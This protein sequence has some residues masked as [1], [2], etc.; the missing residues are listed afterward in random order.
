MECAFVFR[1]DADERLGIGHAMRMLA[2]AE[3]ARA[4]GAKSALVAR[5]LP[6]PIAAQFEALGVEVDILGDRAAPDF[7][8]AA[9]EKHIRRKGWAVIDAPGATETQLRALCARGCRLAV[10]DDGDRDGFGGADLIVNPNIEAEDAHYAARVSAGVALALGLPFLP[11]R[12]AYAEARPDT[13]RGERPRVLVTMGGADPGGLTG[14]IAAALAPLAP[15]LDI[16]VAIGPAFPDRARCANAIAAI[17][18][19]IESIDA[20]DGLAQFLARSDIVVSMGG[21]TLWEAAAMQCAVIGVAYGAAQCAALDA[22][23]AQNAVHAVFPAE[24]LDV[25]G[26]SRAVEI[27]ARAP[28]MRRACGARAGALVDGRGAARCL[29]R[30]EQLRMRRAS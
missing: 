14:P 2:L 26:L 24:N 11:L 22:A 6:V 10:F 20:P 8:V 12:S 16:S 25:D 18:P 28:V 4:R 23:L 29:D 13:R 9:M 7:D 19:D 1:C 15:L 27:L 30:L 5:S 21:V 17:S 3:A